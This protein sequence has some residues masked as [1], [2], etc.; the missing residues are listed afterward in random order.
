M[1]HSGQEEDNIYLTDLT[2]CMYFLGE[3]RGECLAKA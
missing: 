3:E 2:I 1:I